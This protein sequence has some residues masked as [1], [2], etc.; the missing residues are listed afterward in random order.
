LKA[1]GVKGKSVR[2]GLKEENGKFTV[3]RKGLTPNSFW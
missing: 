3:F 2:R 1:K